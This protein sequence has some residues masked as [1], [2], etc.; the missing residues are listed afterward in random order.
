MIVA[1]FQF[2]TWGTI[3]T[4]MRQIVDQKGQ[5]EMNDATQPTP[6]Q[7]DPDPKPV[8]VEIIENA[9]RLTW[10]DFKLRHPSQA[11]SIEANLAGKDIVPEIIA[12]LQTGDQYQQL[13][14]RTATETDVAGIIKGIVPIILE[15]IKLLA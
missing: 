5:T 14:E 7:T 4:A 2:F 8:I 13:L 15:G 10:A 9:T 11:R 12:V 3:E 6:G 1:S